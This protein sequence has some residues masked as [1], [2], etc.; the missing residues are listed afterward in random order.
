MAGSIAVTVVGGGGVRCCGPAGQEVE[1]FL[2]SGAGFGGE[3]REAQAAVSGELHDLVAEFQLADGRVTLD[4]RAGSYETVS[5]NSRCERQGNVGPGATPT[6]PP[7]GGNVLT[8]PGKLMALKPGFLSLDV[9]S[10]M[11]SATTAGR[12]AF[13]SSR[14]CASTTQIQCGSRASRRRRVAASPRLCSRTMRL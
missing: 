11:I 9:E 7:S 13:R 8:M 5:S 14:R 10:K 1:R 3:D 6:A 2:G 4:S 12:P